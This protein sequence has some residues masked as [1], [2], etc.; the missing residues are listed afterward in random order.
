MIISSGENIYSWEVEEAL[1]TH[2]AI[3]EVAVIA[4]PDT[5]WGEAVKA[6]VVLRSGHT[7]SD[8]E[9]I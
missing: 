1:R 8:G 2:P 4:V 5:S 6:C 3:A 9:I 7:A